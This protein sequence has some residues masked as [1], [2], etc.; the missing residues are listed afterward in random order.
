MS[1]LC[2]TCFF[3]L[4]VDLTFLI[5]KVPLYPSVNGEWR[6]KPV[7]SKPTSIFLTSWVISLF[8]A[9]HWVE[10]ELA[11]SHEVRLWIEELFTKKFEVLIGKLKLWKLMLISHS[12]FQPTFC[13]YASFSKAVQFVIQVLTAIIIHAA[14]FS[15]FCAWRCGCLRIWQSQSLFPHPLKRRPVLGVSWIENVV[16]ELVVGGGFVACNTAVQKVKSKLPLSQYPLSIVALSV[17]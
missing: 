14:P 7:V 11:P 3:I 8:M 5:H 10:L 2:Q 4:C 9:F 12:L 6:R 16:V 1:E 15:P 13:P 17:H